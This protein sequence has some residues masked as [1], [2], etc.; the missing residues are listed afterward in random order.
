MYQ[1][2]LL[3]W[4]KKIFKIIHSQW[5]V[6]NQVACGPKS[7]TPALNQNLTQRVDASQD[8]VVSAFFSKQDG[9]SKCPSEREIPQEDHRSIPLCPR[10]HNVIQTHSQEGEDE[11]DVTLRLVRRRLV[12]A[13]KKR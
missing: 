10:K 6:Q 2:R 1:E 12:V 8:Q 3:F 11:G 7:L 13:W 5:A 4:I 9:S